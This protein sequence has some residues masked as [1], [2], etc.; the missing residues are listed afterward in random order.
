MIYFIFSDLEL[1]T[2]IAVKK[3]SK[4]PLILEFSKQQFVQSELVRINEVF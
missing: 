3:R 1:I 2:Y 4:C